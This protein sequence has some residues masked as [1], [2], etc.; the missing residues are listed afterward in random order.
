MTELLQQALQARAGGDVQRA[1]K[2]CAK[3]LRANANDKD[4]LHLM[5]MICSGR[6]EVTEACRYYEQS[7][8]QD[9][10]QAAVHF[11]LGNALRR[12]GAAAAA[13][14]RFERA[15]EL[16]PGF[17]EAAVNLA[18]SLRESGEHDRATEMLLATA[19]VAGEHAKLANAL[20]LLRK[21]LGDYE[22][23]CRHYERALALQADFAEAEHNLAVVLR[24][25]NRPTEALEYYG[26]LLSRGI[27]DYQLLHN[28]ANAYSD[29]GEVE[30]AIAGFNAALQA[31]PDYVHS[32]INLSTL[33]WEQGD[34]DD[35]LRSFHQAFAAGIRT[36]EMERAYLELLLRAERFSDIERFLAELVNPLNDAAHKNYLGR[37]AGRQHNTALALEHHSAAVRQSAAQAAGGSD[38][39]QDE[40]WNLQL[41]LVAAQLAAGEWLDAR[42]LLDEMLLRDSTHPLAVAYAATLWRVQDDRRRQITGDYSSLVGQYNLPDVD[43]PGRDSYLAELADGLRE[44]HTSV[45]APLEQTLVSGTQTRGHLFAREVRSIAVL[46]EMVKAAVRDY[47]LKLRE[48]PVSEFMRLPNDV[49]IN[50]SWSVQLKSSG[51]HTMHMHPLGAISGVYYVDVPEDL[52]G[53]G[54]GC[55]VLGKPGIDIGVELDAEYRVTP[56]NG[57]L[58]LFPSFLWHGTVPFTSAHNRLTI[59]FDVAPRPQ[60]NSEPSSWVTGSTPQQH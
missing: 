45:V 27:N 34:S 5:G 41:D 1:E 30:Q 16:Q 12:S 22:G 49:H 15:L 50:A 52:P 42:R 7:L 43:E 28:A 6:G 9:D 20:G 14:T 2:L 13:R 59:A 46:H 36:T 35:F 3:L 24:L 48:H 51:F 33:L 40:L 44:L 4:A 10:S 60:P 56:A 54:A 31:R 18:A 39:Q 47:V 55:L 8:A 11:N 29:L 53:D 17:I 25:D 32:H 23:A 37:V 38:A 21:D 58:V 19:R 26:R 57:K